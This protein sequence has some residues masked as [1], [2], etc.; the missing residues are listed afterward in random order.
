[1]RITPSRFLPRLINWT[2]SDIHCVYFQFKLRAG[3]NRLFGRAP[4]V[5]LVTP[6][7]TTPRKCQN[8][9]PLSFFYII[10]KLECSRSLWQNP[11]A[12]SS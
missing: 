11:K 9:R 4:P 2:A 12:M 7:R 1:M 5:W 8:I 6:R 3:A 10:T